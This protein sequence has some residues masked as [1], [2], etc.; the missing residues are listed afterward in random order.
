MTMSGVPHLVI[1]NRNYSSW[2]LRPWIA[3]R[4]AGIAFTDEVIALDMPDT[5]D[6]IAAHA[7]RGGYRCCIMAI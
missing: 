7:R 6:R 3:M 1:G 5:K 2:S 4:V